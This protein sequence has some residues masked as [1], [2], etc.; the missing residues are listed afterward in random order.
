MGTVRVFAPAKINLSLH[1]TG[2][3]SDGYHL[4]DTM[5]AFAD[6]GDV[7][8][9]SVADKTSLTVTGPEA[10]SLQ[11]SGDN[12]VTRALALSGF[13]ATAVLDKQLPVASGIGGGSADAA[14]ALRGITCL[15]GARPAEALSLGADVPMCLDPRP[16][17]ATGVGEQLTPVTLPS[18]PAILVNPRVPV[19]TAQVFHALAKRDNPGMQTM[20]KSFVTVAET[21]K[22]LKDQRNDLAVPAI[23]S[24]PRIG[25][26]LTA[27]RGAPGCLLS[28][29]SGSGATCFGLFTTKD[30]AETA[31][32]GLAGRHPEWWVRS[33]SLGDQSQAATPIQA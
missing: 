15:T 26:V 17:R 2:Q 5:V 10:A 16:A 32:S 27:I 25:L 29:M 8:S 31:A 3:R 11:N 28:R 13:S 18:L 30:E 12:L 6:V 20:P 4:L 9:L 14:A 23:A 1:V 7:V 21:I 24:E 22:W 19:S 33:T